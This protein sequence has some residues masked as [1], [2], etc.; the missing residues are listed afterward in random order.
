MVRSQEAL[1]F[2]S[3]Q[4][5]DAATPAWRLLP[6]QCAREHRI[7]V[8]E[9]PLF[10][11]TEPELELRRD[12]VTIAIPHFEPDTLPEVVE[13]AER[14]ML[15]RVLD[16]LPTR[17]PILWYRT[18]DAIGFTHHVEPRAVVYD[19]G[20]DGGGGSGGTLR[21]L[22]LRQHADVV[23]ADPERDLE[24]SVAWQLLARAMSSRF[25]A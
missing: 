15:E 23:I 17:H 4:R 10:D 24:W 6:G 8:L 21:E 11:A 7:V 1:V 20:R 13:L 14:R 2:L 5:W 19:P 12:D 3:P 25:A 18:A 16:E 22:L 9:P